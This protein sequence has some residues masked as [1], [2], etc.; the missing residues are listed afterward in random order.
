[1]GVMQAVPAALEID[2]ARTTLV[3]VD[4]QNAAMSPGGIFEL[5]GADISGAR[6]A[7]PQMR[8]VTRA[9]RAVNRPVVYVQHQYSPDF[10]ELGQPGSVL[11]AKSMSL[12]QY[13]E[14]PEWRDRLLLQGTWGADIIPE[15]APE[16][17]DIVVPKTRY[18]AFWNTTL[19]TVL[20]SQNTRYLAVI[21]VWA[22]VCVAATARD[23]LNYG[24]YPIFVRDAVGAGSA[25]AIEV[26]VKSITP[27][28]GWVATS[29]DLIAALD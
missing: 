28:F 16:P 2:A 4:V 25:E 24:Y 23:A 10:S 3:V 21:G 1:L 14:H 22:N 5:A 29:D 8:R 12:I 27:A 6:D 15:L 26:T 9:V 7:I 17:G 13:R 18:S 11:W 20:R 19:D